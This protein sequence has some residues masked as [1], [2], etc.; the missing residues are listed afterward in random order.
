MLLQSAYDQW[1][2]LSSL[3]PD[4]SIALAVDLDGNVNVRSEFK[5]KSH[6]NSSFVVKWKSGG[7]SSI[8]AA[9][10]FRPAYKLSGMPRIV[11]FAAADTCA[12]TSSR[13]GDGLTIAT[14]G[15][16]AS[17]RIQGICSL[18]GDGQMISLT[19]FEGV[20]RVW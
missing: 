14:A 5:S 1:T 13:S 12:V 16:R 11:T 4:G 6:G 17:F 18:F 7:T 19:S 2:S 8:I 9:H 10:N 20:G 3:E 15:V